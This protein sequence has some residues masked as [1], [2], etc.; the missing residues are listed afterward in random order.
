MLVL[1]T[2]GTIIGSVLNPGIVTLL[3][4]IKLKP[5]LINIRNKEGL[6]VFNAS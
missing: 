4:T 6:G 2:E 3:L 1:N 5:Y